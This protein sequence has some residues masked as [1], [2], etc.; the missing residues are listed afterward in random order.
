MTIGYYRNINIIADKV[1]QKA[2]DGDVSAFKEV[3]DT[4][5]GKPAQAVTLSGDPDNPVETKW[6]VE[7]VN[8]TPESK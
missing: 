2:V 6:T 5:D 4:V 7:F 8:A 3:R 1:V